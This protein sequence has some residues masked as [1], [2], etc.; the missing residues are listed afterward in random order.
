MSEAIAVTEFEEYLAA[1]GASDLRHEYVGGRVYSMAG[2]SERHDLAAGLL[3]EAVAPAARAQGCRAFTANR[4]VRTGSG[5]GYYPDVV[6]VCGP[7]AHRMYEQGPSLV[8][9]VLSPSTADTDRR[10]KALAYDASPALE[11]YLLVDPDAR[12][13]EMA[14]PTREGGFSWESYGPGG[15]VLTRYASIEVDALYDQLDAVATT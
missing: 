11:Q 3:Y 7:A 4:L 14:T 2:G 13:I 15:V 1:E 5:G 6:V 10:E 12:R 9:E 8:I